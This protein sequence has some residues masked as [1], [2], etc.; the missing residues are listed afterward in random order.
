M[1]LLCRDTEPGAQLPRERVCALLGI[2]RGSLYRFARTTPTATTSLAAWRRRELI[3]VIDAIVLDFPGYGYRRVAA[4]LG[5]RGRPTNHKLA[6]RLMRQEGLGCRRRRR[7]VRT[8]DSEHGLRT[9]P[10]LLAHRGWRDLTGVNQA[11]VAD[12]TYIRLPHGFAYLAALLDAYSRKVVGWQLAR[13][14]DARFVTAA[15]DQALASRQPPPGWI[16]HS[17]RGVQYACRDYVQR[18]EAAGARPSMTARGT[19]RENAQAESFFRTLKQEEV[20]LNDY[21]TYDQ[22]ERSL[23]RFIEDIY[24]TKRL[25]S[26]LAYRP[27]AEF[28]SSLGGPF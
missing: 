7:W 17:D 25:H 6:W 20:Y 16:H 15:L 23:G 3:E 21:Q 11:W 2:N 5:R 8:T 13:E 9:Y 14:L 22:A 12:L 1:E 19:P 28:E 27:P 4:E 18:L 10:N 26:A 24:N